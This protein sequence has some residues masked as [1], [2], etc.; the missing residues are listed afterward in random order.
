MQQRWSALGAQ[1]GLEGWLVFDAL[2]SGVRDDRVEHRHRLQD[3]R[4]G[5]P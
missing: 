5:L 2:V 4:E 3:D 1:Q